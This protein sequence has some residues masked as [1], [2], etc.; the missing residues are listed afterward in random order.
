M[1]STKLHQ[2][3][4]SDHIPYQT[5]LDELSSQLLQTHPEKTCHRSLYPE[6]LCSGQV[7]LKVVY[8][9]LYLPMR[10]RDVNRAGVFAFC[11]ISIGILYTIYS[12]NIFPTSIFVGNI[13]FHILLTTLHSKLNF[14][15]QLQS[16]FFNSMVIVWCSYL[17]DELFLYQYVLNFHITLRLMQFILLLCI[18]LLFISCILQII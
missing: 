12:L 10:N 4:Q 14:S 1:L 6:I 15:S 7:I 9:I 13:L 5:L 2:I 18:T 3:R 16:A 11:I 8:G 17:D